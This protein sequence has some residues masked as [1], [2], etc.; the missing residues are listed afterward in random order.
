MYSVYLENPPHTAGPLSVGRVE[1]ELQGILRV[2]RMWLEKLPEDEPQ[3]SK[4]AHL[5]N[6]TEGLIR[7]GDF[8]SDAMTTAHAFLCCHCR[9]LNAAHG[10]CSGQSLDRC[11]LLNGGAQ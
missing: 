7:A 6:L 3:R 10:Q 11:L 2:S 5:R 9:R 8:S 4:I 1:D